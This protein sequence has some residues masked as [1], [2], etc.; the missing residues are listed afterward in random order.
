LVVKR[1]LERILAEILAETCGIEVRLIPQ[2]KHNIDS[3]Q[4]QRLRNTMV[5]YE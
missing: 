1:V 5:R 2:M 3:R 4:K